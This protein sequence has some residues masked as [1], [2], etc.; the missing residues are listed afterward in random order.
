MHLSIPCN[1]DKSVSLS[2]AGRKL[3]RGA[4]KVT[5]DMS[6]GRD[7]EAVYNA[8]PDKAPMY[9]GRVLI[10]IAVKKDRPSRIEKREDMKDVVKPF[11]LKIPRDRRPEAPPSRPYTL[12][13]IW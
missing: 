11:R 4:T 8:Q 2:E 1:Q 9:K 12:K 6:G 5:N 13:V 3:Y 7:E 10:N